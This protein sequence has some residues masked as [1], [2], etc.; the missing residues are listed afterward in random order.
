M[1]RACIVLGGG[2]E[3]KDS[4]IDLSVGVVLN[5][6]V[7]DYV[8]LDESLLAIHAQDAKTAKEAEAIL[9]SSFEFSETPVEKA[10]FIKGIVR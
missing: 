9:L 7:G 5:K 2:R 1:G 3:T 8:N 10:K 4:K 6:K